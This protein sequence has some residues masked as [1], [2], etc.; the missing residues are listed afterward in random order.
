MPPPVLHAAILE[1]RGYVVGEANAASGLYVRFGDVWEHRGWTNVRCFGLAASPRAIVLACGNG[2]LRSR[3]GGASWRVTTD[4]RVTEVLD[5]ALDPH[6]PDR[7]W[8]ATAYGLWCSDD[9]GDTWCPSPTDVG[10]LNARFTTVV[11]P[12]VAAPEHLIVGTEAG[13]FRTD[14]GRVPWTAVGP[15]APVRSVVQ[16]A[17]EPATWLLGTDG[18]GAWRSTDNG[19]TWTCVTAG[20]VVVYAVALDPA[21]PRR[22]AAAGYRTG[23]LLSAD[24]GASW[25]HRPLAPSGPTVMSLAFD[26]VVP[27]RLWVGTSETGVFVVDG[28][29]PALPAGLP[30]ATVRRLV[31]TPPPATP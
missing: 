15:R 2:V 20:D 25:E 7:L 21:D 22:M 18:A 23:L 27:G 29:A 31:W 8:A 30:D 19:D 13:L 5:I 12:D 9:A 28:D 1:S 14:A 6:A 17:S 11:V 3:D 26:P 4:W 16:S 24:G 10:G